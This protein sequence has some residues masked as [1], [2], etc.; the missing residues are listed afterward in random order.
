M[1][2]DGQRPAGEG[3]PGTGPEGN[4]AK[5]NG[6]LPSR[7]PAA[8]ARRGGPPWMNVGLPAEKSMNFGPSA[9]R[10]VGRLRRYR[11]QLAAIIT[12]SVLSVTMSVIGPRVLGRATDIIFAGYIG[13]QLPVDT[14]LSATVARLRANG[15]DH[16]AN[17]LEKVNAVPGQGVDFHQLGRVLLLALVLFAGASVLMWLQAYML[18][19]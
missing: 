2:A 11:L 1:S 4:G 14:S 9:R 7:L 5:G 10:L 12:L 3:A 15:D 17:L 13:R 19:G 16:R 6:P 8:G 18:T